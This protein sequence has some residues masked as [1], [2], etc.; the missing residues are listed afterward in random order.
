VALFSALQVSVLRLVLQKTNPAGF[1]GL[2][3]V[4]WSK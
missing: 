1:Q 3:N 4:C 2:S